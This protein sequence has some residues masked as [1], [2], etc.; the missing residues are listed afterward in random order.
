MKRLRGLFLVFGAISFAFVGAAVAAGTPTIINPGGWKDD[1]EW[2]RLSTSTDNVSIGED[3]GESTKYKLN[4]KGGMLK[5][6]YTDPSTL[7]NPV[8]L[9][10][11]DDPSTYPVGY[12]Y[13]HGL[14][15]QYYPHYGWRTWRLGHGSCNAGWEAN[16]SY[17]IFSGTAGMN[18]RAQEAHASDYLPE[19]YGF[20]FML[21]R[22]DLVML[23]AVQ[24]TLIDP[25]IYI[26]LDY[27]W[28]VKR[29]MAVIFI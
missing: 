27:C 28:V 17:G 6:K 25:Y 21:C 7:Y 8:I 15:L 22:D 26:C 24:D 19:T 9:Q 29:V 10:L 2:V 5:I 11:Y 4:I 13:R 12:Y 3:A 20:T 14:F 23:A 18:W 16:Q 1:G